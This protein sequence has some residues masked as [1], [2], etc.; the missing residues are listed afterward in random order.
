MRL[1]FLPDCSSE[2]KVGAMEKLGSIIT[3]HGEFAA[4]SIDLGKLVMQERR[5]GKSGSVRCCARL[6]TVSYHDFLLCEPQDLSVIHGSC[7]ERDF[8]ILSTILRVFSYE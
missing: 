8:L 3:G 6:R 5:R 1:R 7:G 4:F 2:R